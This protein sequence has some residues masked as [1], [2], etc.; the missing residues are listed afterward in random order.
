M[1]N[2]R[3]YSIIINKSLYLASGVNLDVQ[4]GLLGLWSAQT[5]G[6][7]FL[8]SVMTELKTQGVQDILISCVDDLKG[9]PDTIALAYPH[10]Y[11]QLCIVYN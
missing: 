3:Q 6:A 9:F 2:V 11:I 5:E 10:I 4:K 8:L 7:K 1:V